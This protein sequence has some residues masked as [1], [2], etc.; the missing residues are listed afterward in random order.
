MPRLVIR[1]PNHLGDAC[2]ALPALELLQAAGLELALAGPPWSRDLFA[3]Y[4]WRVTALPG[5]RLARIA[6]LRALRAA[7]GRDGLLLTHSFS[8]ALEFRLAG[9]RAIGYA[10][11]A[12]GWLLRQSVPVP[13]QWR[14][15]MHTI[16]YYLHLARTALRDLQ[17]AQALPEPAPAVPRLR[18]AAQAER[19]AAQ[20]LAQPAAGGGAAQDYVVLCPIARGRHEGRDKRWDGFARL[21]RELRAQGAR[22]VICPGPGELAAASAAVPEAERVGPLDVGAFAALLARSRLVVANDSGPGHLAAAVG[23]R[24]VG[25]FGVTDPAKTCPR[26]PNVRIVGGAR[27][28]PR[29]EEV[30][31]LARAALAGA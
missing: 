24:L 26:G 13:A 25:V 9:L 1:L 20:A 23:A 19:Q 14:G 8:S 15:D 16:D 28:W 27:G 22:V 4:P 17:P 2:M 5:Q 18:V 10:R 11:D 6:A 31:E 21:G 12:R 30:A 29:Y 3:A 7:Q